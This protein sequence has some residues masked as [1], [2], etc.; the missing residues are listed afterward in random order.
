[1]IMTRGPEGMTVTQE[2]PMT[3]I[4]GSEESMTDT[5]TGT[6]R[7]TET[8]RGS[9]ETGGPMIEKIGEVMRG[10]RDTWKTTIG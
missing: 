10:R 1:M 9:P 2:N 3:E 6:G 7:G 8:M 5:T 4:G